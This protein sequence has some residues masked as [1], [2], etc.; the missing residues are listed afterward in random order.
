VLHINKSQPE[1]MLRLA[2]RH[3]PDIKGK[4][5]AVLGLAFKPDTDDI[6]ESP[7]FPILRL[8]RDAGAVLTAYDPIAK[9]VDHDAMKNVTLAGSMAE[10][11]AQADIVVLVTRWNEFRELS[12]ELQRVGRKP[13]VIDGRRILEPSDFAAYEGIGR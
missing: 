5:V 12:K 10:A 1:E 4:R 7:A 3:Y 13:L 9:P 6:R 11:V 8:F 2:Q